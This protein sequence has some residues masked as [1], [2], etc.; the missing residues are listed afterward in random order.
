MTD[1]WQAHHK[2]WIS[3]NAIKFLTGYRLKPTSVTNLYMLC[4]RRGNR[5]LR[6]G[7]GALMY[8]G[9]DDV[10][11]AVDLAQQLHARSGAQIQNG[12]HCCRWR[13]AKQRKGSDAISA[14]VSK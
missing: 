8:S 12:L 5:G 10:L 13:G 4:P 3:D 14:Y 1:F 11:C 2:W 7:K 6:K 9:S